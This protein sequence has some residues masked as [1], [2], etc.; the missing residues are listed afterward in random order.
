MVIAMIGLAITLLF[1]Q[2]LLLATVVE[3]PEGRRLVAK[4]R[5]WRNTPTSRSEITSELTTALGN[6]A[7]GGTS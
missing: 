7:K 2:Q 3:G 4:L 5:L 1:R 6:D